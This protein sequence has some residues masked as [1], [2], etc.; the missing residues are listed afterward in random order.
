MRDPC[1]QETLFMNPEVLLPPDGT[2]L[3][4][5]FRIEIILPKGIEQSPK[6]ELQVT[7]DK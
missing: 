2:Y 4:V 6:T 5:C 7:L 3:S 1:E